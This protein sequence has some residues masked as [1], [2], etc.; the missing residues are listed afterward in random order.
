MICPVFVLEVRPPLELLA[1][2]RSWTIRWSYG[3][4]EG[5]VLGASCW[6]EPLCPGRVRPPVIR[7]MLRAALAA[8][9]Q[10][11]HSVFSPPAAASPPASG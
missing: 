10:R 8:A 7:G 9:M 4:Q 6:C 1:V 11:E 5:V 2:H 3:A